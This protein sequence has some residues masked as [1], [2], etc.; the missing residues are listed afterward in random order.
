MYFT[1]FS[2]LLSLLSQ[3]ES[4]HLLTGRG[5]RHTGADVAAAWSEELGQRKEAEVAGGSITDS[6]GG[7]ESYSELC[8][9][10]PR[11]TPVS[12]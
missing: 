7:V 10:I 1:T 11:V 8:R 4:L 5:I 12:A 6:V 3:Q 2:P 9:C